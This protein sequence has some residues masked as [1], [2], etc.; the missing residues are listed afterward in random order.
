MPPA[1][2]RNVK[3]GSLDWKQAGAYGTLHLG[4]RLLTNDFRI[5]V[6]L[7]CQHR[8]YRIRRWIDDND[9]KRMLGKEKV[10]LQRLVRDTKTGRYFTQNGDSWVAI[11]PPQ[12]LTQLTPGP[13]RPD[14]EA[15]ANQAE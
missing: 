10:T 9:L 14:P 7:A 3:P 1:Q 8:G 5:A 6:H 4:H 2:T 13:I 12:D 11:R 15:M